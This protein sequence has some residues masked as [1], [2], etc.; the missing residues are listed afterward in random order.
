M[1][2]RLLLPPPE[3]GPFERLRECLRSAYSDDASDR[4]PFDWSTQTIA[5]AQ[6]AAGDPEL[7]YDRRADQ[8]SKM[9]VYRSARLRWKGREGL[10]LIRN[11]S[12]TGMMCRSHAR[13]AKDDRIEVEMRSGDCV[14]GLVMWAKDGL[15]GVRFDHAVD[16]ATLLNTRSPGQGQV[17]RMPRLAATCTATLVT[18]EGSQNIG[19][20]DI[21]QGGA[22][23]EAIG[24][25]E[26]HVVTLAVPGLD[27]R[28]G[29][30]RWAQ[31]SRAG[32]AFYHPLPFEA[33]ARWAVERPLN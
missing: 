33:L 22:K 26:D 19:L 7:A 3:T 15:F 25:R 16:V 1:D 31:D 23:I 4:V 8:R 27:M 18:D 2:H 21:S 5:P 29:V 28:R 10:C 30:V 24:L 20:L 32:I 12:P 6:T 11:L 13:P 14:A 17:Q 9:S